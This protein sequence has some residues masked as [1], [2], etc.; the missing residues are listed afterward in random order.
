MWG[1]L[2][3]SDGTAPLS[4]STPAEQT[5]LPVTSADLRPQSG[6]PG[7]TLAGLPSGPAER[8]FSDITVQRSGLSQ[9]PIAVS[10]VVRSQ[11]TTMFGISELL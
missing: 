9:T 1:R 7:P 4:V 3:G 6:D 8:P 2:V 11:P 10:V 5:G